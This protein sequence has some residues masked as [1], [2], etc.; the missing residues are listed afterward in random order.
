MLTPWKES[1][2]AGQQAF[3]DGNYNSA[4]LHYEKAIDELLT[5]TSSSNNEGNSSY[6]SSHKNEHQV[7]LSNVIACRL[8][9]GGI[10]MATLAVEDGKKVC[11]VHIL[12]SVLLNCKIFFAM[13]DCV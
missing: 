13:D 11:H 3:I 10:D 4:L 6:S 7:L 1:K 12:C 5:S 9:I 8:N 2:D